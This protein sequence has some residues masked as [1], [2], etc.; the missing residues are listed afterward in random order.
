MGLWKRE[1]PEDLIKKG[2]ALEEKG[3]YQ[4]A[5]VCYEEA[6]KKDPKNV[7]AY[8]SLALLY[9][10][11]NNTAK[12]YFPA[13]RAQIMEPKNP[14]VL[15]TMA[16][17]RIAQGDYA[18]AEELFRQV[19]EILP[20]WADGYYNLASVYIE[21]DRF[22]EAIKYLQKAV[23]LAPANAVY[24][25]HLKKVIELS[26]S[27]LPPPAAEKETGLANLFSELN[28]SNVG[29]LFN[30]NSKN[31]TGKETGLGRTLTDLNKDLFTSVNQPPTAKPAS[32]PSVPP[33]PGAVATDTRL[34]EAFTELNRLIGLENI[35]KDID[36]LVDYIKVEK[37]RQ[38]AGLASGSI[39]LHTV[40]LG[41]PGTGKTTV[42]R[43]LGKIF[44]TMGILSKGHVI[45]V[46]RGE[47]VAEY[48]GQTATKTDKVIDSA[49]D[50]ILF[51]D[52][53]YTLSKPD[54]PKDYGQ[55]AIDT[56][57]KRMEDDRSRLVVIVAGYTEEMQEFIGSNPGLKSRFNRYFTFRDYAPE[58]LMALFDIFCK[59]QSYTVTPEAREKLMKF[60]TYIYKSRDKSFGNGRFVRNVFEQ[61][62]QAQASRVADH[63][64]EYKQA[65]ASQIELAKL[66]STINL[67]DADEAIGDALP[68]DEALTPE[69][70]L[71]E[72]NQLI[73]LDNIKQEVEA[74]VKFIKVQKMRE[75]KGLAVSKMSLHTVFYGS[76]GTGK[77]TVARLLGKVFKAM[78]ILSKGHVVE[79]DRAELVAG[80]VG[81]TAIKTDKVV[82][83][84][85]H[86]ILFI[87]EAYTLSPAGGGNDFGGEAIDTI[88]KRMEDD[89]DKL[90]VI[91]AGYTDEMQRF[92]ESNPGLKSRFNRFFNFEDYKPEEMLA[93]FKIFCTKG[94]FSTDKEAED[95]LLLHFQE[96]YRDR[97]RNFG[98]GRAVRNLFE[99]VIRAQ[100]I[101]IG[102]MDP[103]AITD[104]ALTLVTNDDIKN[105][106]RQN[107]AQSL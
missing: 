107:S 14:E 17:V 104:E 76:P 21:T 25:E 12:A 50:G 34:D 81:Q 24:R 7:Q 41:A 58:E 88:L 43:L 98:N 52:E 55:E 5:L 75:A 60:F 66:L 95:S 53:A 91:V 45:E 84:A 54:S 103:G 49:L 47:L 100:A 8:C 59:P 99:T 9:L 18:K 28:T 51:I 61:T 63:L 70:V 30:S 93:I 11:Q 3:D 62:V 44:K 20:N 106:I 82:D 1:E 39:S 36:R 77:T 29:A 102:D 37:I 97:D 87:D 13:A 23:E 85:L 38:N 89:R 67:A 90:V 96:M 78:G 33:V 42:A 4:Q 80:Y 72:L 22:P 27:P 6:A 19:V 15:F 56:L 105:T 94:G 65:A 71:A 31:I 16:S 73:G 86:G 32:V 35:K 57:L 101:R 64:Q 10:R 2:L 46:D 68:A 26:D 92:L 48:V 83:S 79:V 74:L 69:Q 40:F